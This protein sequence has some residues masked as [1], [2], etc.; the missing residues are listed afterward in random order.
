MSL[1]VEWAQE[2]QD[3][4]WQNRNSIRETG[5]FCNGLPCQENAPRG[6]RNIDLRLP[7]SGYPGIERHQENPNGIASLFTW[8]GWES[9]LRN[10]VG[11]GFLCS[12][13]PG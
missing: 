9:V 10:P 2:H 5:N 6:L 11:V 4:L 1:V 8:A 7:R 12:A 13:N 3:E